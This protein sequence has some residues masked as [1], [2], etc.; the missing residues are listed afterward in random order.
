MILNGKCWWN[1]TPVLT[2]SCFETLRGGVTRCD[3]VDLT[4][5]TAEYETQGKRHPSIVVD[6]LVAVDDECAQL[7]RKL[8][9]EM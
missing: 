7:S 1:F 5:W 8:T 2:R 9:G 3:V 4:G 6:I